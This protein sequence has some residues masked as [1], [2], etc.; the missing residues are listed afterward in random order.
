MP[1]RRAMIGRSERTG[2]RPGS[3]LTSR[4]WSLP[5]ASQR[6][7]TRPRPGIPAP[8]PPKAPAGR[9]LRPAAHRRRA[10]TP[11]GPGTRPCSARCRRRPPSVRSTPPPSPQR[12]GREARCRRRRPS[13]PV[14]G[15]VPR[16]AARPGSRGAAWRRFEA[17]CG[18]DDGV[19]ADALRA[20]LGEGFDEQRAP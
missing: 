1:A 20:A 13:P 5:E 18:I 16:R 10:G 7:S 2:W 11:S 6:R 19:G 12:R 14:R 4:N 15:G 17:A 3:G 8:R 9:L